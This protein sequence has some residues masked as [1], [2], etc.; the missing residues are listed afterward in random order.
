MPSGTI[1]SISSIS[2][3]VTAILPF[4]QSKDVINLAEGGPDTVENAVALCPN[5]HRKCHF[6]NDGELFSLGLY[7]CVERL[8]R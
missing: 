3:L 4:V 5:C 8:K 6:G 1:L 2:S 7:E